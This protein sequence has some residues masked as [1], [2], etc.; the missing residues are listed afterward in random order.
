M[1]E[2]TPQCRTVIDSIPAYKPGKPPA[3]KEGLE[4]YK[5]SSNENPYPPLPSV[6]KAVNAAAEDFHRY[7]DYGGTELSAAI[8]AKIGV[9][10]ENVALGPGSVGVLGQIIQSTC[11]SGDEVI[12]AWRSFEAYPILVQAAGAT[13]VQVPLTSEH[14]HDLDA[15]AAAV[16]ERTKVIMVCTPNN[17]TGTTVTAEELDGFI[18]KIPG[19]IL[20]VIDEAYLEFDRADDTPDAIAVFKK[21]HNVAVLRTFSKA[22]GLAGLRVGY[23]VAHQPIAE[24]LRKT[25]VP[26]SVTNLAQKAGLASLE[27]QPELL[28]RVESLVAER[29]RVYDALTDQGWK[30]P[31]TQANFVWLDLGDKAMDFAALCGQN[32]LAVRPFPGEG[33]RCSI[34]ET[35][36]NDRLIEVCAEFRA[37]L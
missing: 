22:Y 6:V 16:T 5:I 30:I 29:T 36:A 21:H 24:G 10:A 32:A 14:R 37:S 31:A 18:A 12:F 20:I 2:T 11:N 4:S 3:A 23:G 28:E 15:M 19:H 35:E 27:A 9:A 26:F 34:G 13:A 7:P 17:P 33:V 8:A 1:T 25:M